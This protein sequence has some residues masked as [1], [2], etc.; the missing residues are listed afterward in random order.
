MDFENA[1]GPGLEVVSTDGANMNDTKTNLVTVIWGVNLTA[2]VLV[3]L[4][5]P[6]RVIVRCTITRN[7]FSDDV[8]V[9]IAALF[10]F[11]ICSLLP[12]ATD[13]GLGQHSQDI[14][15]E[16]L[17]DNTKSLLQLIFIANILYPCAIAFTRLSAICSF[18]RLI[19]ERTARWL[20]F[21][22][23]ALT[24]AFA[25]SSVFAVVFQC[26]PV[27]AAWDSS[28]SGASCFP[29]LDFLHASTA[30]GIGIDAL[31]CTAPLVYFW[32]MEIPLRK[33]VQ[34]TVLL[35]FAGL[36]CAAAVIKIVNLHLLNQ[37]DITY[38][39]TSWVLFS[40]A[41]CTVGIIAISI[42]PILPLFTKCSRHRKHGVSLP[43]GGGGS[44]RFTSMPEKPIFNRAIAPRVIKPMATPWK[45]RPLEKTAN[46]D[47]KP[48]FQ[49]LR[50]E[51]AEATNLC[52]DRATQSTKANQILGIAL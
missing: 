43:R 31:L 9:I 5:V 33:K 38:N 32:R 20:L 22:A 7:F 42:P 41:E 2:F 47:F 26:R 36:S 10:T 49:W 40:I 21:A 27:S 30:I 19:T 14:D 28:T 37:G 13:L 35:A 1:T 18:L 34:V 48:D 17:P 52:W 25:V 16:L 6:L 24:S 46:P 15:A 12:I 4:L 23:A 50:L 3:G 45:D 39:W 51:H 44:L 29:F 8:L 11:G